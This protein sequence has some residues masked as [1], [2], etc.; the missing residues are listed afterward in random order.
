[1]RRPDQMWLVYVLTVLQLA[2]STLFE[3]AKTAVIPFNRFRP[4]ASAGRTRI[5]ACDL[6]CDADLGASGWRFRGW[7]VRNQRRVR[8]RLSDVCG[9]GHLNRQRSFSPLSPKRAESKL[10]LGR[11]LGITEMIEASV[12]S[13]ITHA[14]M[15]VYLFVKTACGNGR[16]NLIAVGGIR[17]AD[18]PTLPARRQP[19]SAWLFTA[20]GI[21]TAVGP[22][23]ARRWAGETQIADADRDRHRFMTGGIFVIRPS[24]SAA[25]SCW[26][27][28]F[29][30]IAHAPQQHSGYFHHRCSGA[31]EDQSR[32][33]VCS[34]RNWA[35]LL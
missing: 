8:P 13:I 18:F 6:V 21:D 16:R 32:G 15:V 17:R 25:A 14:L 9:F 24:A 2:F 31:T 29:L 5:A 20:R 35:W 12:M 7:F 27:Y 10:T 26:L 33:A 11:A 4:R 19:A 28:L 1:M 34:P 22:F 30:A 23:I 3:P